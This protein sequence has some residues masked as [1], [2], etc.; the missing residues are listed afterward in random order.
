MNKISDSDKKV[1]LAVFHDCLM[2]DLNCLEEDAG[3]PAMWDYQIFILENENPKRFAAKIKRLK[4]EREIIGRKWGMSRKKIGILEEE[5]AVYRR[6]L[7]KV[8]DGEA[9]K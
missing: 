9:G 7:D 5:L 3:D 8:G 4:K 2:F 1:Y 6:H